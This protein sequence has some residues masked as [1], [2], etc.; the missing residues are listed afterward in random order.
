MLT[1]AAE[2]A[3]KS[4]SKRLKLNVMVNRANA[5]VEEGLYKEALKLSKKCIKD[6]KKHQFLIHL[7]SC[8]ESYATHLLA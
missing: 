8:Y 6:A 3:E 2:F 1:T 5:L 7:G 4:G